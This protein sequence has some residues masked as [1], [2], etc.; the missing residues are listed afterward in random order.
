MFKKNGRFYDPG[1]SLTFICSFI[2]GKDILS[3]SGKPD[4]GEKL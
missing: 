4:T 2:W 3:I 1:Y